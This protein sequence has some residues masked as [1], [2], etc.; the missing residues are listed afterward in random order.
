MSDSKAQIVDFLSNFSNASSGAQQL[1]GRISFDSQSIAQDL[2]SLT[3][4]ALAE[5]FGSM[6]LTISTDGHGNFDQSNV[7]LFMKNI[8]GVKKK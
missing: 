2:S 6:Q 7:M 4:L 3:F 1:E 5:V 8:G